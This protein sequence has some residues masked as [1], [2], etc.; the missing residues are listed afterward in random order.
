MNFS[1]RIPLLAL[2][3]T[4][5][6]SCSEKK[7]KETITSKMKSA[8]SEQLGVD[9]DVEGIDNI[10]KNKVNIALRG[11]DLENFV[12]DAFVAGMGILNDEGIT[13]VASTETGK[14]LLSFLGEDLF[15]Q[16]PIQGHFGDSDNSVVVAQFT[17]FRTNTDSD[18]SYLD[19]SRSA[20]EGTAIIRKFTE[21]Y[22]ELEVDG[23][24]GKVHEIEQ[25]E[26][27]TSFSGKVTLSYPI[28]QMN[29]MDKTQVFGR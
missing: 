4:T 1:I 29:G 28:W 24:I 11:G 9:L 6:I 10:D 8:L 18:M 16:H 2:I 19:Q 13:F 3:V 26:N 17:A 27:W 20:F 23:K 12:G 5:L 14:I 21:D 7:L 22:V 15:S 25:P